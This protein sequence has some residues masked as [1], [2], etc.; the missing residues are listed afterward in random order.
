MR[1]TLRD[2]AEEL[3]M[4]GMREARLIKRFFGDRV[5]H[6]AS[7]PAGQ[8]EACAQFDRGEHGGGIRGI[9][10]AGHDRHRESD[11]QHRKRALETRGSIIDGRDA[12]D[13]D[14]DLQA[15]RALDEQRRVGDDGER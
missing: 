5:R 10:H 6:D 14:R 13:G 2:L 3:R 8:C 12:L 15:T 7:G 11:R 4:A 1:G 9:G